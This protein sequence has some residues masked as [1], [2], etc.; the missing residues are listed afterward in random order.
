MK[1]PKMDRHLVAATQEHEVD[2]IAEKF[3]ITRDQVREALDKCNSRSRRKVYAYIRAFI[4]TE[5]NIVA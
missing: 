2:Y 3:G 1:H 4:L 5:T